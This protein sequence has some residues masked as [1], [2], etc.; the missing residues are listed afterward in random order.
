[1]TEQKVENYLNC[2]RERL[3]PNKEVT[4]AELKQALLAAPDEFEVYLNSMPL[5]NPSVYRL[6]ALALGSCGV[7]RFYLQDIKKGVLKFMT[8]GGFLI[9][10][11]KDVI[12]AKKRCKA[13]NCK[14]LIAATQ[15]PAVIAEMQNMDNKIAGTIATAKK[16]APVVK[17]VVKGYKEVQDSF[18]VN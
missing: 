15:N 10:W 17:E 6:I 9:W 3:F 11:F 13:Y 7:D 4:E 8:A 5:R 2:N 1:M 18:Y 16:A 12:T 14:Q